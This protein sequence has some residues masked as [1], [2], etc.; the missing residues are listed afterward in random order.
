MLRCTTLINILHFILQMSR[1][2]FERIQQ[3]LDTNKVIYK[4]L[5]HEPTPTSEQAAL[6]RERLM[7]IP[8]QQA[9]KQG[10]K[11]MIVRSKGS[12]Y[13]FVV[14]AAKKLDFN[15]IKKI[16]NTDS[17]SLATPQEVQTITDCVPGSVPPFGN[18]F[19][20]QVYVDHSLLEHDDIDFNAGEQTISILMKKKDWQKI[21]QPI[22][23]DFSK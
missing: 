9:L 3:L 5:E 17:A 8:S 23:A 12:F 4:V 22:P 16:L 21:V 1:A 6:V 15:K 20:I 18:L 7:G 19:N 13:Q 10:A 14:S 2:V 11:A